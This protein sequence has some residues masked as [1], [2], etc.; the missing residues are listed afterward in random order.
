MYIH[1]DEIER[2]KRNGKWQMVFAIIGL[3]FFGIGLI[4]GFSDP[5]LAQ[6]R[7]IYLVFLL[8]FAW[9][10]WQSIKKGQLRSMA[11]RYNGIFCSDADGLISLAQLSANLNQTASQIRKELETLLHKGYLHN[12]TLSLDDP[13]R[14]ILGGNGN[15]NGR[16]AAAVCPNCGANNT[17]REGYA[18]TCIYCGT[19]IK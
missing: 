9:M 14:M 1:K 8:P 19:V 16:T 3:L 10:L 11:R 13:P 4:G 15:A 5:S 18:S 6:Y 17:V 7:V 12:C 2:S